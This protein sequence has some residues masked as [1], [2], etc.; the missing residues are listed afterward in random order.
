M[1]VAVRFA[2]PRAFV[3]C[4]CLA[5]AV[6][7]GP[8]PPLVST[9]PA[10]QTPDAFFIQVQTLLQKKDL[11][12]YLDLVSPD[13]R[14]LE[15]DRLTE[16]FNDFQ[17]DSVR[18]KLQGKRTG[19]D[20]PTR[21]YCQ[22]YFENGTTVMLE[23]WQLTLG[24][25]DG[26]WEVA[27]K[28]ISGNASRLYKI[29]IPGG[30]SERVRS[31]EI[32][33]RDIRLSFKDAVVFYDNLP[34]INTAFII[35]GKGSVRFTPSDAV[36]RHQVEL[37]YGKP[38]LEDDVEDAYIRCS[39][40]FAS[41][42]IQV[43]RQ[44]G[45]PAVTPADEARASALFARSYPRSFTI[46]SSL[47]REYLSLLPQGDE[48]VFDFKTRRAGELTYIYYPYSDEEV[49]LYDRTKDR[50]ISLY[51]PSD[52]G[53]LREKRFYVS[54]ADRYDIDHY[55]LDL[56]Y[57][58]S[59]SYLSGKARITIVARTPAL[60][61]VKFRFSSDL[62]ILKIYDQEKREL[63]YTR[64]KIRKLLYVSFISPP[65]LQNKFWI[66]VYYRGRMHP[67]VPTSDVAQ[68]TSREKFILRPRYE[69]ALFT[70]SAL[71]YPEPPQ[72]DYFQARLKLVVPP[73]YR[74]IASGELVE[75]GRWNEMNDVVEIE[76][77]GNAVYTFE[78]KAPIKYMSFIV[79][80][81]DRPKEGSGPVP[82]KAF[83]STEVMEGDP[84]LV[85]TSRS[86][87]DYYIRSFGPY[88]FEKLDVVKRLFPTAGGHS[89]ASF[90]VLDSRP[91]FGDPYPVI[92]DSPVTLTA[93]DEYFLAH[94]LAHQ[95]WGQGVSYLTYKDQWLSEGLAQFAAASYLRSKYGEKAF[96]A[97]LA[98]FAKWVG[99]KS[100][101][102]PISIGSRLS[103][104]DFEAYQAVVYD[105]A[106]LSLFMLQD[107]LGPDAFFAG[108]QDF[109]AKF[110]Y[111]AARTDNFI[112]VMERVSGRDLRDFFE[113]WFHSWEL[114][115]V[116][117]SWSQDRTASGFR[118]KIRVS[119]TR[120]RFVFPLW[121]EWR[122]RGQ[123]HREMFVV[124]KPSQE[125][126]LTLPEKAERV[127]FNPM[128][129][130]P[131]KIS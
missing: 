46:E 64:D 72:E 87:L 34:D 23:F 19:G 119:Q 49:S 122:S 16:L 22:A 105:K 24:L 115:A 21:L 55:Q 121:V 1:V 27:A 108:L 79:G 28:D 98:K 33:H 99:K 6:A 39:G 81:F 42:R 65:A 63:F 83:T 120:G 128:R 25:R 60:E 114:P 86:I 96:G 92:S 126:E 13:L 14:G 50:I 2:L 77:A 76:K 44:A 59:N 123:A 111:T 130:V 43:E 62:E 45:L 40:N 85:D 53:N 52:E 35:I 18:L 29:R 102:G 116:Q 41:S 103:Y 104:Y 11:A 73:E 74:C 124:D 112:A 70:Q 67:P 7:A 95:W 117:T 90:V 84:A 54:F 100:V 30:R 9:Q 75:N 101:K 125:F 15:R 32:T 93:W 94:E 8:P 5:G 66:E 56:S 17:M 78:T 3:A 91:W 12:G 88:P 57:S 80:K 51:S 127:V 20:G 36:E 4:L 97:I 106:A 10:P 68:E 113:G 131:G 58:P 89:P 48:A 118:L 31:V 110:K 82:I 107:I 26:R 38:F 37:L 71:W 69:T 61:M 47:D 109:F 129:I